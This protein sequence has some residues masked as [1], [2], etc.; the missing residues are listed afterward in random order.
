MIIPIY[1]YKISVDLNKSTNQS[2]T[3]IYIDAISYLHAL[4]KAKELHP[5][6]SFTLLDVTRLNTCEFCNG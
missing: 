4:I 1:T 6:S 3:V 5:F 2:K